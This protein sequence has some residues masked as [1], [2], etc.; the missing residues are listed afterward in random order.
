MGGATEPPA[1]VLAE[2]RH[3]LEAA[4]PTDPRPGPEQPAAL[5][6]GDGRALREAA[7]AHVED[8]EVPR[9]ASVDHHPSRRRGEPEVDAVVASAAIDVDVLHGRDQDLVHPALAAQDSWGGVR[10]DLQ[11][12]HVSPA[13]RR[14]TGLSQADPVHARPSVDLVRGV[15]LRVDVRVPE[16]GDEGVG[17]AGAVDLVS[18]PATDQHVEVRR[19]DQDVRAARASDAQG[20]CHDDLVGAGR[21]RDHAE[22]ADG[23]EVGP[24]ATRVAGGE[25]VG[26][27]HGVRREGEVV[28]RQ[29]IEAGVDVVAAHSRPDDVTA[30]VAV[31][32]AEDAVVAREPFQ[33]VCALIAADDVVAEQPDDRVVA[34]QPD[35]HV[36]AVGPR[37][38]VVTR[39]AEMRRGPALARPGGGTRRGS[40]KQRRDEHQACE[41]QTRPR[42]SSGCASA[43]VHVPRPFPA[44]DAPQDGRHARAT[45]GARVPTAPGRTGRRLRCG[46]TR[47]WGQPTCTAAGPA[48]T[49]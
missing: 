43:C 37:Q 7:L 2:D 3:D 12:V 17:A 36:V 26:V 1:L 31:E 18:T 27:E 40:G 15:G 22:P 33:A 6:H 35:H 21:L 9:T 25:E 28:A 5:V 13:T 20:L 38:H 47:G 19:P 42:G 4:H 34:P 39:R 46:S 16:V 29:G 48:G 44:S 30:G 32:P 23:R 8:G 49:S 24:D 11:V 41:D 14:A 45:H 10:V